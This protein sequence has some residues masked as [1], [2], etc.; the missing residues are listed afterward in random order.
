V[1]PVDWSTLGL[2]LGAFFAIFACAIAGSRGG[3][4][5]AGSRLRR[6]GLWV[7]RLLLPLGGQGGRFIGWACVLTTGVSALLIG[8]YVFQ[9]Y[10]YSG[11]EWGYLLQAEIFSRS[12]LQVDSPTHP[13]FFDVMS[14]VNDGKFYCW[15]PPGWPLLLLPGSL[16]G[17]PWLVNPVLGALTLLVVYRLGVLVYDRSTSLLALL[18]MLF[19]PFF[20]LHSA[21]Y[22]AHP[23]SLLF[24]VLFVF[25][26]ARGIERGA[27]HDFLLAGLAG[28]VSFL[29]RPF[30]QVAIF[31]PVGIHL[32][33]LALKRKVSVRRLLWFGMSHATGVLLLLAY[34]Y[35]QTGNPLTTGYHIAHGGPF[36]D[37]RLPG[38]QFIAE[39][40]LHL[41][42]W[43]FPFLPLLALIYSMWP[44]QTEKRSHTG[45]RWDTLLLLMFLSNVFWYILVPFHYWAGYGPRYYYGSFF[46]VALLGARGAVALM[47]RLPYRWGRGERAGFAAVALGVCLTLSLCWLFPVKL[48]EAYGNVQARLA[49]YRTAE[50]QKLQNAVVFIW[51]GKEEY[52]PF[53]LTR[54]PLDF[55]A[56]VLYVH[57][58][59][60]LNHLLFRQYPGRRFFRYEYDETKP[61]GLWEITPDAALEPSG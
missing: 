26:Y 41:L 15:A 1:L 49:L 2:Q 46:A 39:Y 23:S 22:L 21:S 12:R 4:N 13:K 53:N 60:E 6:I 10:P 11:D 55:Q 18:F 29:I 52:R 16:L 43:T 28:S 38:R 48:L 58:L 3:H 7:S 61:A 34:N 17:V 5:Q 59:G 19:S 40:F 32:L 51:S 33:L 36:F 24:I 35:L 30:D 31:L 27:S 47:H 25:F 14:M 50:H 8:L 9:D 42:V 54:N 44:R 57:D 45:Q 56:P 20:L 37:L